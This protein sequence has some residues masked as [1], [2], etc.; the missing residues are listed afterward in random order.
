VSKLNHCK[1]KIGLVDILR[2]GLATFLSILLLL[3]LAAQIPTGFAG[4]TSEE[5]HERM[6]REWY[7]QQE[8]NRELDQIRE[9]HTATLFHAIAYSK[10]TAKWGYAYGKDTLDRAEQEAMRQCGEPDAEVL[11]WAKGSWYCALADGPNS[12]GGASAETP[13]QAKAEALR[14]GTNIAPGCHIVLLVGGNPA[15]VWLSK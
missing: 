11:C 8:F 13:E 9:S 2:S 3:V 15:K 14:I 10:S 7:R 5:Y 12:Y 6:D 4:E 1:T